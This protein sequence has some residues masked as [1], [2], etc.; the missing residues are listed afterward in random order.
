M[1]A[2]TTAC[3]HRCPFFHTFLK[4]IAFATWTWFIQGKEKR[5]KSR[6]YNVGP[7]KCYKAETESG[8]GGGVHFKLHTNDKKNLFKKRKDEKCRI[9]ID[10]EPM[11]TQTSSATL[12][13]ERRGCVPL[14]LRRGWKGV[15]NYSLKESFIYKILICNDRA[16]GPCSR[17]NDLNLHLM[18]CVCCYIYFYLSLIHFLLSF[19]SYPTSQ[20]NIKFHSLQCSISEWKLTPFDLNLVFYLWYNAQNSGG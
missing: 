10:G 14:H 18:V 11:G 20:N 4:Q 19:Y 13:G 2:G 3:F 12:Q 6:L 9:Q 15:L 1:C 8:G 7:L 17:P 5:H 16:R